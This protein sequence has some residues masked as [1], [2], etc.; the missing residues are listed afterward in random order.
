MRRAKPRGKALSKV[1]GVSRSERT[2]HRSDFHVAADAEPDDRSAK[3]LVIDVLIAL[4]ELAD[5][6][7]TPETVGP[8]F[9][10]MRITREDKPPVCRMRLQ[11]RWEDDNTVD[12]EVSQDLY[13]VDTLDE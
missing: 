1:F 11:A 2:I 10:H 9:R 5:G 4:P 7:A 8:S 13:W 6:T 12:G 3:D